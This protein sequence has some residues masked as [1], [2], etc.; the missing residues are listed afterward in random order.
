MGL[1]AAHSNQSFHITHSVSGHFHEFNGV[2][3]NRESEAPLILDVCCCLN[4]LGMRVIVHARFRSLV[5]HSST[6]AC[7][8]RT[9]LSSLP[10]K[11]VKWELVVYILIH[12]VQCRDAPHHHLLLALECLLA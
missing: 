1:K 8:R 7:R 12:I 2:A 5:L 11:I 4:G 6:P 10:C 3:L 9:H